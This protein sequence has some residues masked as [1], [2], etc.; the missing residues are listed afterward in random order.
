MARGARTL[1][2]VSRLL[3]AATFVACAQTAAQAQQA[4]LAPLT[5]NQAVTEAIDHNLTL[6]AQRFNVTVAD[7]AIQTASLRPNPVL[8]VSAM[9]PDQALFAAGS[10]TRDETVRTDWVFERGGK[11]SDRIEQATLA[12]TSAELNVLDATRTLVLDVEG[13]FVEVQVAKLNLAL[14]EQNLAAFNDLVGINVERVRTGDLA[15]VELSRSQLAML[16]FQNDVA[17]QQTHLA[18]ARNRLSMLIG[19]GPAGAGLDVTGELRRDPQRRDLDELRR[20]ALERRPD[21][22]AARTEQ[23]RSAADLRLQLANGKVD[24]TLS[25]EYHRQ[26]G[27]LTSGNAGLASMSVPLPIF[28]RNQG[29]IARAHAAQQ[30]TEASL[31][32]LEANVTTEVGNAYAEYSSASAVVDRIER[33]MLTRAQDVRTTTEY[34]YRRGEAS[35]VELLDAVRA[36]NDTMQSYNDA[37]AQY[38]RS[39]YAL[40]STSGQ[41]NP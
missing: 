32:A 41:V 20:V 22:Q 39:L 2:S 33:D 7:A 37:R 18:I 12:K 34:A 8:T 30:Q 17:Q 19:R 28:S 23:A 6:L 27:P 11:R 14:A 9:R 38:A 26:E 3:T 24:L 21:V 4:V 1:I 16:Q 25:G 13:A 29:E 36:F 5:M 40:E 31:R 10:T 35:F 15:G